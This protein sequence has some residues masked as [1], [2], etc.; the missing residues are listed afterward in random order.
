MLLPSALPCDL[1]P[2]LLSSTFSTSH[3]LSS[4]PISDD[5]TAGTLS[6]GIYSTCR[7]LQSLLGAQPKPSTLSKQMRA[8]RLSAH[9]AISSTRINTANPNPTAP[10]YPL[11]PQQSLKKRRR[12]IRNEMKEEEDFDTLPDQEDL[13]KTPTK[14]VRLAP[15]SLP[16]G[17]SRADFYGLREPLPPSSIP[18][19]HPQPEQSEQPL[20][21]DL[22]D[23][24]GPKEWDS[25]ADTLLV[26]LILEKLKLTRK[27]WDHCAKIL[28]KDKASLGRRWKFLVGE[29]EVGLRS[30]YRFRRGVGGRGRGRRKGVSEVWEL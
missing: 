26:D 22:S 1:R 10:K 29:G 13:P 5:E 11:P 27:D 18:H 8:H 21:A 2:P 4:P 16:L 30:G 3:L 14:R 23:D 19:P 15:P 9:P 24:D 7:A 17:L 20:D 6:N 12:D 25:T 28:G